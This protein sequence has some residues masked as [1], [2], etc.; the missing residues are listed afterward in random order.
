VL[1]LTAGDARVLVSPTEGGRIA[2]LRIRDHELLVGRSGSHDPD[3]PMSW[4]CFPLVPFAGRVRHG[5]FAF[6]DARYELPITMPP[7]AIHGTGYLLAWEVDGSGRIVTELGPDWP[8]GGHAVQRF[9]L[10]EHQL[11]CQME[12][13]ADARSMPAQVGWHPWFAGPPALTFEATAMY[14]RDDEHVPTGRLVAPGA[15][16]WDDCFTGVAYPPKLTWRDTGITLEVSSTCDHWVVFTEPPH[17][18]CVEPQ[19]GPP[20]AFN[21]GHGFVVVE[22]GEPLVHTMTWRW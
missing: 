7:N 3:D 14:E 20:D 15:K 18:V 2:S 8:F 17:A 19:C 10:D 9:R 6:D 12:V 16:P 21:L 11:V 1:D 22:P 4:G 5:E 13:H